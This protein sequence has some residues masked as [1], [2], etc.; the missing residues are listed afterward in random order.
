MV[1][2]SREIPPATNL[3]NTRLRLTVLRR[4]TARAARVIGSMQYP[5]TLAHWKNEILPPSSFVFT[6][7]INDPPHRN[8]KM[9]PN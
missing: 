3:R 8:R 9:I 5:S 2:Q 1:D 4:S 6:V 7:I